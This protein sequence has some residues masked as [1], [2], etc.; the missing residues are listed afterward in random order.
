MAIVILIGIITA[1]PST[2]SSVTSNE[3][4]IYNYLTQEMGLNIAAACGVLANI[5][6]ESSFNPNLTGDN[7][8]SYGICQ[9][10]DW[11]DGVGRWTEL[12]KFCEKRGL[13]Y[14]TLGAQLQYLDYEL[15]LNYYKHILNYLKGVENTADG[16]YEAGY[17]FCYHFEAPS[18]KA[19]K[20]VKRGNS[21]RDTYWKKYEAQTVKKPD[22]VS[23]LIA[24]S[25]IYKQNEKITFIWN[26]AD[27]A[28]EYWVYLYKDE[29]P[30]FEKNAAANTTITIEPL[31]GG[32]YSLFVK[33][34]NSAGFGEESEKFD[35]KVGDFDISKGDINCDEVTDIEDL[36]L[37]K[38]HVLKIK[39]VIPG[40]VGYADINGDG[41][42]DIED[43][44]LLKK[45]VL[46]LIDI[47]TMLDGEEPEPEETTIA[48]YSL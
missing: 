11:G 4:V 19:N 24:N 23:G 27:G 48:K 31:S 2:E 16:A 43:L 30:V 20:S 9:W 44:L 5:Y 34:K 8:T 12:K 45:H 3:T 47:E 46:K 29:K 10:H 13:D 25:Y 15:N 39:D 1:I 41:T 22:K 14:T 40:S 33:A 6:A 18:D 35:F 36:L 7:G 28:A 17:Y 32:N 42:V 26:R 38:K 37:L 21:A